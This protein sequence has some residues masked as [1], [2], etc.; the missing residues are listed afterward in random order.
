MVWKVVV[1]IL[2]LWLTAS[3]DF[4]YVLHGFRASRGTGTATLKAKLLRQLAAMREAVVYVIFMDLHKDHDSLDR[5]RSQVILEGWRG[6]PWY[7][8]IL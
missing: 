5:D 1:V 8:R 7:R 6:G 4:Y 3:I 2:N